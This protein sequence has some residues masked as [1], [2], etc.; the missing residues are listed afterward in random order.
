MVKYIGKAVREYK[1]LSVR[2]LAK[3]ADISSG[4]IS[5][6]EN[7]KAIP[8]LEVLDLVAKVMKVN[9]FELVEFV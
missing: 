4:T 3:A 9:P 5:K 7:G 6:W 1:G 8:D 2:G